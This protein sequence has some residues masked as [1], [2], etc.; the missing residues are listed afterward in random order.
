[1]SVAPYHETLGSLLYPGFQHSLGCLEPLVT[2]TERLLRPKAHQWPHLIWRLDGGFG[3]DDAIKWLLARHT[4]LL[5]KGYSSRR[6]QKVVQQVQAEEWQ[7]VRPHKWV[8]LVPTRVRYGR[9]I[10]TLAVRWVTE[11]GRERC[12]LLLHT[13]FNQSLLEVVQAYDARGGTMES[14]LHQDKLGLQLMR[15]RKQRWCAQ[16]AWVILNDMA[17]NLLIWSYAWMFADSLFAS[18]GMFRLVHD[19]LNIP[20]QLEFKGAQLQKVSLQRS[21]PFAPE[22]LCCLE[23][24]FK[25]LG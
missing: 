13:L 2:L 19:V 22:M 5:T 7:V 24:L 4:Q 8:A 6:A 23:R 11:A 12:A 18:Y 17:H 1:V 25:N 21:H 9:S 10:Q 3:S 20:G 14:D 16:E 15:R